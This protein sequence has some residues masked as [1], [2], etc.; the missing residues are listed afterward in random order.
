MT[1]GNLTIDPFGA[2]DWTT[3][4]TVIAQNGDDI[5]IENPTINDGNFDVADNSGST[6]VCRADSMIHTANS[7]LSGVGKIQCFGSMNVDGTISPGSSAGN[8]R[9]QSG[10]GTTLGATAETEIE[11]FS[12]TVYDVLSITGTLN[13]GGIAPPDTDGRICSR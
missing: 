2:D 6:I 12:D 10:M 3:Q 1:S 8:L 4:G 7:R 5:T 9:L 13:R 11:L